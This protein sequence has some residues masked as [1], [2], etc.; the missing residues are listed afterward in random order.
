MKR[1]ARSLSKDAQEEKRL[2][3]IRMRQQGFAYKDIAAAVDVHIST[4]FD[5]WKRYQSGGVVALE[6][7][8][9]GREFGANRSLEAWQEVEL[10]KLIVGKLPEQLEL[11]FAL[12]TRQAI[13][14]L[15]EWRYG[16]RMPI[17]TVGEYLKRW[18]YTPQKPMKRAMEQNPERV[19]R[20]L[21]EEYPVIAERAKA[22]GG[23]I[24]WG[25]ETGVR[26][27]HHAGRGFAPAG[28]TPVRIQPAKRFGVN[29]ISAL[30]NRGKLRFMLYEETMSSVLLIRFFRQ[31][32]KDAD[33]K[34]FLILDNLR[35]HHSKRVQ[36]WLEEHK[37]EIEVFF[38]P[39]Y[40]PE[41]N[42]DEYLNN[43][44]KG[45]VHTSRAAR[46]KDELKGKV[47]RAM[48]FLQRRPEHVARYFRHP[49]IAYAG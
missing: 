15:I 49:S 9:R 46:N 35:V 16:F 47:R 48:C 1:D 14:D 17:R 18:G 37:E 26:S 23:E 13:C 3:A 34:M 40:S 11:P 44:L 30:T 5:W 36:A 22:E 28:Q 45:R 6:G 27:D 41:L 32:V 43:D 24:H 12:W 8:R 20:W 25:D 31:L 38:L 19:E 33:R 2:T 42:P 29:M 39:P 7:D 10:Q 4:V 21:K